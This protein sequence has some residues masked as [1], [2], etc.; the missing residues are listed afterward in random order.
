VFG[1]GAGWLGAGAE[2]PVPLILNQ[3]RQLLLCSVLEP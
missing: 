2:P 1:A 3:F